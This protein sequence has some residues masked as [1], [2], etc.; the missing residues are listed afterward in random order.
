MRIEFFKNTKRIVVK[1]GTA[2][3]TSNGRFCPTRIKAIVKDIVSMSEQ[4]PHIQWLIVSSGAVS[5]GMQKM[6]KKRRPNDVAQLQALAAIGQPQVIQHFCKAFESSGKTSAQ[7]LLTWEDLSN[8]SRFESTKRTVAALTA[9]KVFTII[10]EN[11]TVS[12]QEIEFGDNDQLSSMVA[13][14]FGADALIFLTDSNGFYADFNMGESTRLSM[15]DDLN[16]GIFKAIKDKPGEHTRGGMTSKLEA[17]KKAL[18]AGIPCVLASGQKKKVLQALFNGEDTGTLFLP[19]LKRLSS[20]KHWIRYIAKSTG[21]ISIDAGATNA[22]LN[23]GKSLLSKGV[24]DIKGYFAAGASILIKDED[25]HI[26]GR[27]IVNFTSIELE[28]IRGLRSNEWSA[29]LGKPCL[30]EILH[31]DNFVKEE[32]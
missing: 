24:I 32:A 18:K 26:V 20:K 6:Q 13:A 21:S 8:R 3:L 14:M 5:A 12:T 19:T 25:Q 2:A 10:N 1:I 17:V 31:R 4:N 11:D 16:H 27:G 23:R 28:T 30:D 15:V 22:L 9:A 29:A 7:V